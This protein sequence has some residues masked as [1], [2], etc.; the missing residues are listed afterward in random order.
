MRPRVLLGLAAFAL[1]AAVVGALG[2]A[3]HRTAVYTWP[4]EPLPAATPDRHWYT[5]LVLIRR[6]PATFEAT[7]PCS[8]IR[9][10]PRTPTPVVLLSTARQPARS[11]ALSITRSQ[12]RLV[13]AVGGSELAR[14]ALDPVGGACVLDVRMDEER[15]LF[16]HGGA[17]REGE[18]DG[19]GPVVAGLFTGIDLRASPMP[20]VRLETVPFGTAPA[21]RQKL[22]WIVSALA[23]L[24]VFV[25][26]AGVGRTRPRRSLRILGGRALRALRPVDAFVVGVL[27]VWWVLGPSFYDDGWVKIRQANY[28]AQGGFSNYYTSYGVNFPLGFWLEWMQHWVVGKFDDVLALR[29]PA[30]VL[31]AA[32]W[33]VSRILLGRM[34]SAAASTQGAQWTLGIAFLLCALSW[35][36]TLRPEPVIAFLAVC[37]LGCA[38]WFLERP[39]PA[40]L[41]LATPI[42]ALGF[43][44]HP[45]GLVVVAPL[46]VVLPA[47][48]RWIRASGWLVPAA[49]VLSG[50]AFVVV[51]VTVGADLFQRLSD[52]RGIRDYGDARS[53][54]RG[55]LERYLLTG[56]SSSPL[57]RESV[58]LMVAALLA[59][60][61]RCD[62]SPR[63]LLDLP[64]ASLGLALVLMV[65]TPSKW[66]WHFGV[67]TGLAAV[68]IAAEYS[69]LREQ[70]SRRGTLTPFVAAGIVTVIAGWHWSPRINWGDL[71]LRT[72]DW[73]PGFELGLAMSRIG[74]GLVVAGLGAAVLVELA[75]GAS[76]SA[77]GRAR[78]LPWLLPAL[79]LAVAALAVGRQLRTSQAT[80]ILDPWFA[81]LA[82]VAAGVAAGALALLVRQGGK[83]ISRGAWS[84]LPW[85]V[86]LAVIP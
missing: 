22:A 74:W 27:L 28:D 79:A 50:I 34:P 9:P 68:A 12:G 1:I 47:A 3:T 54:W 24:L 6:T 62:R 38:A 51:L 80:P 82:L 83:A 20:S 21:A 32:I 59:F 75:R 37:S 36:V 5:P 77:S 57:R 23:I 64:A 53:T 25:A 41:A 7:I 35:N 26:A 72:L 14:F 15:W 55:E 56:L 42:V 16:R 52:A 39:G 58:A 86:P 45:A 67:L 30:L 65:P 71:D 19:N 4:N 66:I 10:L 81:A 85:L 17:V 60:L 84:L 33:V 11:G 73:E 18:F 46:L 49:I 43:T 29:A 40:P 44:A 2:P 13:A 8:G 76:R 31:V 69:R 78:F 61:L 48:V 63:P 70:A